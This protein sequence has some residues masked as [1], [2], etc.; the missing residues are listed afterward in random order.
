MPWSGGTYTKGNNATGGWAGDASAGIGIEAGRHDTQ[1]NDF[2]TGI[3]SCLNK[4][5]SNAATANLNIGGFRL[6]STGNATARNDAIA[7]GQVQDS[8]PLWGGTS[9]GSANAQ[10]LTL[11]PAITA[12]AAGQTF[13]FIAGYTNTGATTLNVNGVGAKNIYYP[14]TKSA[15]LTNE[16]MAGAAYQVMYDGTQFLLMNTISTGSFTADAI[17]NNRVNLFKSRGT[18]SGTN[19]IV[20]SGDQLGGV[21]FFGANG[22]GYDPAAAIIAFSDGTP[23]ASSDMPGRLAFYTTTDGSATLIE[24]GR[25]DQAGNLGINGNSLSARLLVKGETADSLRYSIALQDSAGADLLTIRCDGQYRTG[26]SSL[27]PYNNTTA[28]AANT[29]VSATGV[30]Q[31]STSSLKYKTDVQNSVHGLADVLQLRPVTYKGK[32]DGNTVF[33][34]LIAEEVDA[35]GLTEFVQYAEDGTPDALAYGNMVSLAFKAIQ[36]LNA[37][38]VA[39]EQRVAELEA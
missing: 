25:F 13:R 18:T 20:Q 11:T 14:T 6:T 30:L 1:D 19:T 33:G 10:T 36:E 17:A 16:I 39:L 27:S 28:S 35:A 37:K 9:G 31:R 22:T 26:T 21:W 3:N 32:N 29:F 5:G 15:L 2:T 34:G 4:D 12:Y 7:A 23:G 38:I 8:T 24:R